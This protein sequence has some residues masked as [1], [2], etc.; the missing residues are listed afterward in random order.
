MIPLKTNRHV[1]TWLCVFPPEEGTTKK[2]RIAHV[3]FS[4]TIFGINA[5]SFF[6]SLAYFMKYMSI[7]LEQSIF[8]IVQMLGEVNMTYISVITF[9]LRDEVSATYKSLSKIYKE[10]EFSICS[11]YNCF[12]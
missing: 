5:G 1:L 9:I 11:C 3:V 7:D 6:V 10:R 4:L 12:G 2:K 8:A